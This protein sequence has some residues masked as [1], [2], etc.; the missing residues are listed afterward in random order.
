VAYPWPGQADELARALAAAG[1]TVRLRELE[2]PGA[3]GSR[4]V[5]LL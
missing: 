4:A 2:A 3:P 1:L 5:G